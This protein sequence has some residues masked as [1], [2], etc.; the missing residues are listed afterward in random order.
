MI[1]NLSNHPSAQWSDEQL[2]AAKQYG[3]LIDIKFPDIDPMGDEAYIATLVEEYYNKIISLVAE[4]SVVV[5]LMGEMTF[6]H[7]LVTKLKQYGIQCVASCTERNVIELPNE[8]K[9]VTFKFT[10]FREY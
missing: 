1:I 9:E 6:T 8:R 10:Q 3:E 7:S 4:N 2:F 5:H